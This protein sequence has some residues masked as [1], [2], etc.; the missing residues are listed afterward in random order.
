MPVP[1]HARSHRSRTLSA[2]RRGREVSN[3]ARLPAITYR[4]LWRKIDHTTA[5]VELDMAT[6]EH[7]VAEFLAPPLET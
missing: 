4:L 3:T 5:A 7:N 1:L 2:L 6:P